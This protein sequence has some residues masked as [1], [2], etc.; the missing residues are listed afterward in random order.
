LGKAPNHDTKV[1]LAPVDYV[2]RAIIH[3]S[4]Q[5][6]ALGQVF[7][8][9]NPQSR[10]WNGVVAAIQAFG[11]PLQLL[12]APEWRANLL[13]TAEATDNALSP[14][15]SLFEDEDTQTANHQP[16]FD[17]QNTLKGLAN[18]EIVCPPLD[19]QLIE[20]YLLYLIEQGILPN[21]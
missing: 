18:T 2:S 17:C 13:A 21:S 8:L 11:Y 6:D 12:P 9:V 15:L 5:A 20:T 3:L 4:R 10:P 19:D 16:R 14:L 1:N 7:H